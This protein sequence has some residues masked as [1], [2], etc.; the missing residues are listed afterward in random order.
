[1]KTIMKRNDDLFSNWPSIFEDFFG[2]DFFKKS[3]GTTLPA[4]NVKENENSFKIEMAIPG[5]KKE[6]LKINLENNVLTIS[7]EHKEETE[8]KNENYTRK[9]FHYTSFQ[10]SFALP[11]N[12]V[13]QDKIEAT[14]ENGL[15]VI[16]IPKKKEAIEKG[17]KTI[18]IR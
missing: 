6:D 14:Y 8:D 4:V 10:R 12:L 9:E 17:A 5:K 1:M 15:L 11:E 13:E 7:S 18:S 2:N 16:N 3:V